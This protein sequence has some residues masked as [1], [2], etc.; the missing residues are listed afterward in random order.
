MQ[1]F[2]SL[3]P[4][5]RAQ[6][7]LL[8]SV[9]P[10]PPDD[11]NVNGGLD[12]NKRLTELYHPSNQANEAL[13]ANMAAMPSRDDPN[14]A[15]SPLRKIGAVIA[16]LGAGVSPS[17]IDHGAAIGFRG[18]PGAAFSTTTGILDRPFDNANADW[19]EKNKALQFGASEE[20]R[21]NNLNRQVAEQTIGRE[22]QNRREDTNAKRLEETTRANKAKEDEKQRQLEI[23][24]QRADAYTWHQTH[25]QYEG[26][27]DSDGMLVYVNKTNPS[28]V[29][30]TQIDTGKMNDFDKIKMGING[31]LSEIAAQG[32]NQANVANINNAAKKDIKQTAPGVNPAAKGGT[33]TQTDT[34]IIPAETDGGIL[35]TG[36]H[37]QVITPAHKITKTKKLPIAAVTPVNA[38]AKIQKE[39]PGIPGSLAE[40][41]DGGKTWKRIK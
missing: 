6:N 22:V 37:A 7:G 19:L 36:I 24:Q 10:T 34:S 14:Y 33:E 20:T 11:P 18:N 25:P 39:I 26:K 12:V 3:L 28:D 8:N 40:S 16:G 17:G 31:R 38:P 13:N 27:T 4:L 1:D 41:S 2:L 15:P 23:S 21:N 9:N 5:L 29:V 30:R 35:G 32:K